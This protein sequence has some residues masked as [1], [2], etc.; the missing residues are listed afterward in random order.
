MIWIQPHHR[1]QFSERGSQQ[2]LVLAEETHAMKIQMKHRLVVAS[3]PTQR[4]ASRVLE[5]LAKKTWLPLLPTLESAQPLLWIEWPVW[6][7]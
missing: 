6:I 7:Q 2:T 4:L 5:K 1:L 3:L